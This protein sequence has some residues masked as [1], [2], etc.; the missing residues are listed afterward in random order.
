M[1]SAATVPVATADRPSTMT[2]QPRSGPGA[3]WRRR[4]WLPVVAMFL[5]GVGLVISRRPDSVT[6]PQFWAEDGKLWFA[7]AYDVGAEALFRPY[8]GYLQTLPRFIAAAAVG[9][10]LGFIH[11]ALL[12]N[13]IGI[14][15]QAA[16]AAFFMSRRFELAVPRRWVRAVL[17]LVY[18]GI[19]SYELEVT[20]TNAQWH[21]AILAVLVLIAHPSRRVGW[22]AFDISVLVLCGLTGP[23]CVLLLP[24]AVARL[25][26]WPAW[27]RWY[28]AVSGVVLLTAVAQAW[29]F[30]HTIRTP[31]Q[32]LGADL[33]TL[34]LIISDRVILPGSFAEEAH[35]GVY[36]AGMHHG[37]LLAALIVA[38]A[39]VV[40]GL[41]LWRG[42]AALRLFVLFSA[43]IA[44]AGLLSPSVSSSRATTAW[45]LLSVTNGATRYFIAAELAWVACVVWTV[46]RVPMRWLRWTIASVVAACF[47]VG[48]VS[49]WRYPPYV[50]DHPAAYESQLRAAA[51]G[52]TLTIPLNPNWAM[53]LVRR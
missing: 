40:G 27:R 43:A 11:A 9:L 51:P 49:Q 31:G 16:P 32:V 41:A 6:Y 19:P 46:S 25:V 37:L 50:D 4:P 38:G 52:T 34:I 15:L 13:L 29:T 22:R 12:F 20:I 24:V 39:A 35:T 36:T 8:A 47:M 17:G 33:R 23:F 3:G 53:V 42:N 7:G 21:L 14:A 48:L 18:L 28:A 45:A 1:E 44:A 30:L 10:D 2:V 5:L 26:T